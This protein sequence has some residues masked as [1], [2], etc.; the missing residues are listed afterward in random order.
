RA[1]GVRSGQPLAAARALQADLAAWA[2]DTEAEGLLLASL[3]DTLY[4]YSGEVSL[5]PPRAVLVEVGASLGLFGGWPALERR[6]RRD[7]DGWNLA[8][9]LV[10]APV[11]GGARVLAGTHDGLALTTRPQL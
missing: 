8:Y 9:R 10:A 4:R 6:L 11:A 3:A 1:A 7:F 2:R 5:A